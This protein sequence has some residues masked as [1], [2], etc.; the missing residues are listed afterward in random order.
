MVC[1]N[2]DDI[3]VGFNL[4]RR[5][6]LKDGF[7][8][9]KG[10]LIRANRIKQKG[11]HTDVQCGC[12]LEQGIKRWSPVASLN[13]PDMGC[14]DRT[15]IGKNF[16]GYVFCL[17][18]LFDTV[19]KSNIVDICGKIWGKNVTKESGGYELLQLWE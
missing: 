8:V 16:L 5:F 18:C 1:Q 17:A 15:G 2:L 4:L 13:V 19:A 9:V 7:N 10:V 6:S 12:Y 3:E 14:G 11:V